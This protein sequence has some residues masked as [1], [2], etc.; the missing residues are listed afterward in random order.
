M[1]IEAI[2]LQTM[3]IRNGFLV[4]IFLF[5]LFLSGCATLE[6]AREVQS[7]RIAMQLGN[8]K[9]AIR[10]FEPAGQA[11]PGYITDF[12]VLDIRI[13]SY[14]GIAQF[15]EG[16]QEKALASFKHAKERHSDDYFARIFLGLMRSQNGHRREGKAELV[17]G[18]K[19]LGHWLDK[20][21]GQTWEGQFWD[22]GEIS[23]R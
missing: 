19:G 6:V 13:W 7:G 9:A 3:L 8:H 2:L 21:S 23:G 12:T 11:K 17:D 4:W 15:A 10:H 22:P 5:L 16:E 20:A 1:N 18:L 14:V